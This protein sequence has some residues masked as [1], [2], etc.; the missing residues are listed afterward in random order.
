LY[1]LLLCQLHHGQCPKCSTKIR[2]AD[3]AIAAALSTVGPAGPSV[4][5]V[6][7][8]CPN[9]SCKVA[10]VLFNGCAACGHLFAGAGDSEWCVSCEGEQTPLKQRQQQQR[11]R[12]PTCA[13][14]P[15]CAL[16]VP[17]P[18]VVCVFV[19]F[20]DRLPLWDPNAAAALALDE[21]A[22][23]AARLLAAQARRTL[24]QILCA[25]GCSNWVNACVLFA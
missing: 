12:W 23:S 21:R 25:R 1:S 18:S 14:T 11:R 3:A 7:P 22:R 13:A 5:A 10:K 9:A 2:D 4:M 24:G 20:R 8:T 15:N 16:N 19:A 6:L 17:A